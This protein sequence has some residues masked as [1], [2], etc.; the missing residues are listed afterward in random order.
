MIRVTIENDR[1]AICLMNQRTNSIQAIYPMF[2]Y[3]DNNI[4]YMT[5]YD[6][7]EQLPFILYIYD[8]FPIFSFLYLSLIDFY[9][10][11]MVEREIEDTVGD[12]RIPVR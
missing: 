9:S 3:P 2:I 7:R 4:A 10:H 6:K 1:N 11:L 12:S 8:F 5:E